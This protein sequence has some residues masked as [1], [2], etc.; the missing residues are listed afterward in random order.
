LW[1][2]IAVLGA[3]FFSRRPKNDRANENKK[4]KKKAP[5]PKKKRKSEIKGDRPHAV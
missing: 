2:E 5:A 3:Y 1:G 4:I